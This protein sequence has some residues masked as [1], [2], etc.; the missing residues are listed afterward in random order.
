MAAPWG[1]LRTRHGDELSRPRFRVQGCETAHYSRSVTASAPG[2]TIWIQLP[3][4][5][6]LGSRDR[7]R[8]EGKAGLRLR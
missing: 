2:N 1:R 8:A 6:R 3:G 5:E 4:G 7:T